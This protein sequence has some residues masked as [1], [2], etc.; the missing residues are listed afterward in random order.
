MERMKIYL[1]TNTIL[2][3]FINEARVIKK[4]EPPKVP[5]KFQF[6]TAKSEEIEF[7]TSIL[8]KI[9][10]VRELVSAFGMKREEIEPVWK[11]FLDSLNCKFVERFETDSEVLD[12]VYSIP[13]RLRT[14]INFQHLFIAM[15]EDAYLLTGDLNLVEVVRK[16]K[17]YDKIMTYP[18]L[19][20]MFT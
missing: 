20:K 7:I 18:E 12:I 1:D 16:H 6:L 10:I 4:K 14:V 2:D 13:L 5:S 11:Q 19:R 8:T 9:E 3:F 15:K 17:L